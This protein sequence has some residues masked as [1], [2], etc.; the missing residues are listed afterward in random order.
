MAASP[1][2]LPYAV[3]ALEPILDAKTVRMHHDIIE[4]KYYAR[5][6]T[7]LTP[8]AALD[9]SALCYNTAGALLHR[10]YWGNLVTPGQGSR[11]SAALNDAI[12]R[13]FGSA[14]GFIQACTDV[15]VNIHGDGWAIL[16][17]TPEL[18]RLALMGVRGHTDGLIPGAEVLLAIDV[19][20]HAYITRYG[21]DRAAYVRALWGAVNWA[22]VSYRFGR[23][24]GMV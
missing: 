2:P 14:K 4:A 22:T 18:Q 10:M 23:A 8:G 12:V 16:A 7:L 13:D 20:E 3:E 6:H 11:P 9:P 5:L 17:W 15:A 24:A 21:P 19:W 1:P